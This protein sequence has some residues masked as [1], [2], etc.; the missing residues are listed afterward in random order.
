[1]D[2]DTDT[3]LRDWL[4]RTRIPNDVEKNENKFKEMLNGCWS[5]V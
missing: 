2:T 1:M 5:E 3:S 4:V